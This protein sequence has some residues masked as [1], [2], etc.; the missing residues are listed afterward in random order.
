MQFDL[1]PRLLGELIELR[2]LTA[3]D[4]DELYAVGS[5]PLIWEQHPESDRYTRPVFQRYFYGAMESGGAFAVIERESGRIIGS[6]RYCNLR[7]DEEVE[8]GWTFLERKFWGGK[9]NGELKSLMIEHALRFVERVVFVVGKNNIRSQRALE[10]IG[11]QKVGSKAEAG[12]DGVL[13]THVIFAIRRFG[14]V[15]DV[16]S[17]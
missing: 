1:Q 6:S 11:A 3:A 13:E 2:P 10:K 5:D 14:K 8:I 4:W 17:S 9:Y 12:R 15:A 7:E 16:Q